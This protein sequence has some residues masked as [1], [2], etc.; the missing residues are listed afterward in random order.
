[1]YAKLF[2]A[3]HL[4]IFIVIWHLAL[5][6]AFAGPV[7]DFGHKP[8]RMLRLKAF[9]KGFLKGMSLPVDRRTGHYAPVQSWPSADAIPQRRVG[10]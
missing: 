10:K 9:L 2:K 5:R 1:M 7:V 3:R 6:W 4:S 8:P